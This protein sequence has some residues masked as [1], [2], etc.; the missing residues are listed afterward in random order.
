[1]KEAKQVIV[2]RRDLGM[3]R[4]KMS[5]QV[6]HASLGCFLLLSRQ[7]QDEDIKKIS[8]L[9]K[10][11]S[12]LD[13]WLNGKFTKIVL[14]VDSLDELEKLY[15]EASNANLL[16]VMI[17]DAGLTEFGN[18]PTKTC[19]CIGPHFPELI[20]PVTGMLPLFK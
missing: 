14:A 20:D 2:V 5:S 17:T 18:I 9:F 8:I 19:L 4:G 12:P 3:S 15:E 16:T 7:E 11:D 10:E 13:C 1:M 6:A